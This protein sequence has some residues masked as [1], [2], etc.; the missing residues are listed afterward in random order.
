MIEIAWDML[1]YSNQKDNNL[2]YIVIIIIIITVLLLLVQLYIYIYVQH[3]LA[4]SVTI[5]SNF[6]VQPY[7]KHFSASFRYCNQGKR[8]DR[9]V[10]CPYLSRISRL[11]FFG[12]RHNKQAQKIITGSENHHD[13]AYNYS[14]L[15][16]RINHLF[17]FGLTQ[18]FTIL[19]I[20]TS[21]KH[22]MFIRFPCSYTT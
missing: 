3:T 7:R 1:G 13:A 15:K 21:C 18:P 17:T 5:T 2:S 6:I 11:D 20:Q 16:P 9:K 4:C 14:Q 19:L 8:Q 10:I 12:V 22:N